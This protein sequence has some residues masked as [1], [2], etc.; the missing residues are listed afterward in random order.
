MGL[1]LKIVG[2]YLP[3]SL[4]SLILLIGLGFICYSGIIYILIGPSILTD[5]KKAAKTFLKNK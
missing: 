1:L 2:K 4:L 3:V 5:V